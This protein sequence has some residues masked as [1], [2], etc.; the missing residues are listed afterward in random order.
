[1]TEK[2]KGGEKERKGESRG[3][4]AGEREKSEERYGERGIVE[5]ELENGGRG[6]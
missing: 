4:E 5:N 3:R 1:M 6:K 2:E